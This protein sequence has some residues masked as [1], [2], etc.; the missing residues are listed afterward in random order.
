MTDHHRG[1]ASSAQSGIE[2]EYGFYRALADD[3]PDLVR[4][5]LPDGTL[6]FVNQACCRYF[7]EKREN[8]LGRNL[9]F[10]IL[11]EDRNFVRE[12]FSS[13]NGDRPVVTYAYRAVLSSGEIRRLWWTDRAFPGNDG[14]VMEVQ[15]VGRDVTFPEETG[16]PSS[17]PVSPF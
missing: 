10:S 15:S 13:L 14:K 9:V 5:F 3:Q 8:L 17:M 6:T 1:R 7:D 16:E 11:P 12:Q 2:E 4:R